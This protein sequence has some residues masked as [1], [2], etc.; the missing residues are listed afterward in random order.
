MQHLPQGVQDREGCFVYECVDNSP[1]EVRSKCNVGD[2]YRTGAVLKHGDLVSVDLVR[3]S[4]VN[5]SNNGPFLRLSDCSGWVFEKKYGNRMMVELPVETGLWCFYVDNSVGLAL[6]SHPIDSPNNHVE[7][8]TYEPMQKIYCDRKVVNTGTGVCFY[9]VQ[10][11]EGWIFDRR[12]NSNNEIC[13]MLLD[14]SMVE[15]GFFVYQALVNIAIRREPDT[16]D[17]SR[18]SRAVSKGDLVST[19]VVRKSPYGSRNGPFLRLNDGS[20]WLFQEKHAEAMMKP[21]Q[22]ETG[23]WTLKITNRAGIAVRRQP[24]DA[25]ELQTDKTFPYGTIVRCDRMVRS[26]SG[27]RFYRMEQTKNGWLFDWRGENEM[28]TLQTSSIAADEVSFTSSTSWSPDFVRGLATAV[29]ELTEIAYIPSSRLLSFRT[30]D[31]A[32]INVYYTTRTVGTAMEHPT[33]GKTQLFRR[34]CTPSE[35]LEIFKNP[36]FHT[37]RGYKRGR[38]STESSV[39]STNHGSGI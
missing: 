28:M 25:V 24:I 29:E 31:G 10:G 37:G 13:H 22:V 11:T 3:H 5:G 19:D 36:R 14:E 18:T 6:R 15:K 33:Q 20:G 12:F 21:V 34:N 30:L 4:R 38:L 16:A 27:V 39:V 17:N 1:I 8:V 32:R 2:E 35:L 7:G 9:R 23:L 26:E